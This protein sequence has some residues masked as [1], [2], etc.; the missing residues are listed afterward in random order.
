VT[1]RFDQEFW[2]ER[3]SSHDALWSGQPN[4]HLVDETGDLAPGTALDAGAGEGA[5]AIW[6]ATRGWKVTAVDISTVAL[7]R[8]AALAKR[9]GPEIAERISWCHENLVEWDPPREEFDLVSSQY[10]HLPTDSRRTLFDRLAS[11]VVPGGTLLIVAHHPSDMHTT[12]QRPH[13]PDLFFTGD[14]IAEQLHGT[15]PAEW[16][17]VSNFAAGRTVADHEGNPVKLHD[18]VLRAVRRKEP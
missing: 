11:A 18:T 13:D 7:E 10:L 15:H 8:G 5:D 4:P 6:L 16:D 9:E 12:I 17:V 2:D 3:Y 14:E 1:E